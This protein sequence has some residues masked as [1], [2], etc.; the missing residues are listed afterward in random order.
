MGN[1]DPN[2]INIM[3]PF[4][5]KVK[6]TVSSVKYAQHVWIS[7]SKVSNIDVLQQC[8]DQQKCFTCNPTMF[9][10]HYVVALCYWGYEKQFPSTHLFHVSGLVPLKRNTEMAFL[11][12]AT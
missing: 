3:I 5:Y 6:Y 10:S 2:F 9:S 1:K 8:Q 11:Q 12:Q 4:T 7:L